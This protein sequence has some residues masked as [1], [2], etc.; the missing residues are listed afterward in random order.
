MHHYFTIGEILGWAS[1][2]PIH[3]KRMVDDRENVRTYICGTYFVDVFLIL[4]QILLY[5]TKQIYTKVEN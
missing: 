3:A 4:K 2:S 1:S 5:K